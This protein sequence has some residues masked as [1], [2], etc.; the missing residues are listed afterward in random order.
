M[1]RK[2]DLSPNRILVE[3]DLP[4]DYGL[5]RSMEYEGL[6]SLDGNLF[7]VITKDNRIVIREYLEDGFSFEDKPVEGINEITI[8]GYVHGGMGLWEVTYRVLMN[9]GKVK[10]IYELNTIIRDMY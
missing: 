6:P 8:K 1:L 2:K 7:Y 4:T 5:C 9:S 3:C 10:K